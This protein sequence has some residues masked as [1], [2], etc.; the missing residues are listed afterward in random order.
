MVL[1]CGEDGENC[2]D[3]E[4]ARA[5]GLL[6]TVPVARVT[7]VE[8]MPS[9]A[10]MREIAIGKSIELA[11]GNRKSVSSVSRTVAKTFVNK[12]GSGASDTRILFWK[13]IQRP[14]RQAEEKRQ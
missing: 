3:D 6:T 14:S 5:A 1:V 7:R 10:A 9:V 12:H 2:K 8:A 13:I 11:G 4:A